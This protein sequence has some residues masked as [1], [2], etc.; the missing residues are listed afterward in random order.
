MSKK[1]T[2]TSEQA[3]WIG[4][5]DTYEQQFGP[6][7]KR[8]KKIVDRFT[9]E[10][11][12]L[13]KKS[14]RFNILWSNIQTLH[15]AIYANPP[16]PNIDR[17][18]DTDDDLGRYSALVLERAASYYVKNDMFDRVMKQATLDR[19]LPGRGVAWVRYCPVFE[20]KLQITDDEEDK[21]HEDVTDLVS[22][23]VIPD[24]VHWRD[25]GHTW[26]RTWQEVRGVWRRV[27]MTR[28]EL[29]KRFGQEKGNSIPLDAKILGKNGED[30]K[31]GKKANIY[32]IW[33]KAK[34]QV[35][36]LHKDLSDVIE[37]MDDPLGLKDFF[38]CPEPIYATLSNDSLIPTPDYIQ[39]QDQA[40]ELDMLTGRIASITKSLKVCGVYDASAA[41]I[42]R[43]LSEQ[44]ENM[45]IPVD[46]WAVLG[47]GKGLQGAI[48][49]LPLQEIM[50]TLMGL[51][52]ARER[53]KNDLYEITGISDIVRGQTSASETATAQQIKGQFATLRLDNNQKDVARFSRDMVVIM[54]EIIAK[55]FSLDT[56]KQVSGVKLLTEQEK[57]SILM[58][59]QSQMMAQSTGQ[60]APPQELP[61]DIQE[62]LELPTWEQ[63]EQLIRD[64]TARSFRIDIETD[65]TIK[66]DQESEKQARIEFLGAVSGFM[67][68][69]INVPPDLQE[70]AMEMLMFG[71]RGFKVSREL[72]TSFEAAINKMRKAKEQPQEPQP[73][74]E[75][76][77]AQ[78]EQARTQADMQMQQMKMQADGQIAQAEL[79]IKQRE[80]QLKEKELLLKER[81]MTIDAEIEGMKINAEQLKA[82]LDAKSK[83]PMEVALSDVD[84]N[85]TQSP[86]VTL[87]SQFQ[88]QATNTQQAL[89]MLAQSQNNGTATIVDALTRPKRVEVIRDASGQMQSAEVV[90]G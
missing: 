55:H 75:A 29:V 57:Q 46:Q 63:V 72:E 28:A 40:I 48:S 84:M 32:E 61:E 52:E 87:L 43:L 35:I 82:R 7:E 78:A 13:V 15:P 74:P 14:S 69:A 34:K 6:W 67:A 54:T 31:S 20:E 41:G 1:S 37:K 33:D 66:T 26:A 88:E 39:Y 68:Q 11:N 83:A 47:G 5:I 18:F 62:L 38:P 73:N 10:R 44:T 59:Q 2:V 80:L 16:T 36:W 23:D 21:E 60:Q 90:N 45:L 85:E 24:Y 71:V 8:G 19:L 27:P 22:E 65:S 56:I 30:T 49:F 76:I 17:R 3:F 86:L 12:D 79:S 9:D 70:L 25:F 64:D 50:Q 58:Q 89:M 51:Y 77:K 42:D 81:Q 53:V 4:E